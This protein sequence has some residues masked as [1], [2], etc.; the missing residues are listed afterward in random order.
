MCDSI[1][2]KIEDAKC[3]VVSI[4]A[5]YVNSV[6][7]GNNSEDQFIELCLLNGYIEALERYD[8]HVNEHKHLHEILLSNGN[9][10]VS[11]CE[12]N[13]CLCNTKID[14]LSQEQVCFML[15]QISMICSNS[16]CGC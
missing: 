8:E 2:C 5:L 11:L 10:L 9:K 15:N 6:T 7:F 12:D 16:I 1:K 14:C 4:A 13:N 3:C